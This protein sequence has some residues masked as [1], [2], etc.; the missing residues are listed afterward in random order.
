MATYYPDTYFIQ[1][2]DVNNL[3]SLYTWNGTPIDFPRFASFGNASFFFQIQ[4]GVPLS[5]PK[6]DSS[7]I[8]WGEFGL[9]PEPSGN[10]YAVVEDGSILILNVTSPAMAQSPQPNP[11]TYHFKLHFDN[12][13]E[14][15]SHDGTFKVDPT[16]V[17]NP[18]NN[19]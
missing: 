19:G 15:W 2:N 10:H 12:D 6:K 14:L 9:D 8:T 3:P 17:E 13:S 16:I 4:A 7:P 5:F 18:P 11:P 1:L